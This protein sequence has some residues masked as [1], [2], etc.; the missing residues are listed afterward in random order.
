MM[1]RYIK[2][3][4]KYALPLLFIG[5]L[6]LV[7]IS[8]CTSPSST[9]TATPTPTNTAA[10]PVYGATPGCDPKNIDSYGNGDNAAN[11]EYRYKQFDMLGG[12]IN[13]TGTA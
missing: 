13:N 7:S 3:P 4:L 10:A 5:S 12:A 9:S 11:P 2:T 1:K 6:V 8:G